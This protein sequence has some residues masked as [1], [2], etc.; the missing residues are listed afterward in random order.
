MSWISG[1]C[2]NDRNFSCYYATV[3]NYWETWCRDSD[4]PCPGWDDGGALVK[5][6]DHRQ[7]DGGWT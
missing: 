1:E 3:S 6:E 2:Q 5:V 7:S 4:D